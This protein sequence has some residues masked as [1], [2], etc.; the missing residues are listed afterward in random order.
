MLLASALPRAEA[1]WTT[2]SAASPGDRRS[3]CCP[4]LGHS[5]RLRPGGRSAD[6]L[7]PLGEPLGHRRRGSGHGLGPAPAYQGA[8]LRLCRTRGSLGCQAQ[9]TPCAPWSA[10]QRT[11]DAR[12]RDSPRS[13]THDRLLD[14]LVDPALDGRARHDQFLYPRH[15]PLASYGVPRPDAPVIPRT[16]HADKPARFPWSSATGSGLVRSSRVDGPPAA[17]SPGRAAGPLHLLG[18]RRTSSRA[19]AP[20]PPG[21]AGAAAPSPATGRR[22]P[23]GRAAP[24]A[25]SRPEPAGSPA[26]PGPRRPRPAGRP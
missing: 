6:R 11:C 13:G 17:V 16:A 8:A 12:P 2:S 18:P 20:G 23:T 9:A 22:S 3:D 1:G 24:R 4:R 25:A 5:R 7:P 10:D 15:R 26:H 21:R 19:G 14:L